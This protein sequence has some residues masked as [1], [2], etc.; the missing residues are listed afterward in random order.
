MT[1]VTTP[2]FW[3]QFWGPNAQNA[4]RAHVLAL[5]VLSIS[6]S[7]YFCKQEGCFDIFLKGLEYM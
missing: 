5:Q 3:I 4:C 7:V 1:V 2:G 6:L